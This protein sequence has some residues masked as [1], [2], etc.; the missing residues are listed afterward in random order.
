MCNN[1][2]LRRDNLHPWI[3]TWKGCFP[4]LQSLHPFHP[5][6]VFNG[7]KLGLT[8]WIFLFNLRKSIS[9]YFV[10]FAGGKASG[11]SREQRNNIQR[12][13]IKPH[14]FTFS[15]FL[16]FLPHEQWGL[17]WGLHTLQ[18][19]PHESRVHQSCD[20]DMGSPEGKEKLGVTLPERK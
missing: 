5:F 18:E 11:Q 6:S 12:Q 9:D 10:L 15:F 19:T 7:K 1:T 2:A 3:T 20:H 8:N 13:L 16:F 17:C 4:T 14:L